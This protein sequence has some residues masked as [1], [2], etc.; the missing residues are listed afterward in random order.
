[1]KHP[2]QPTLALYAG[3]DLGWFAAKRAERHVARCR[4]CRQAVE[5]F[6]ALHD[7]LVGFVEVPALSW[8]R[9]AGEMKANIRLGLAAGECV[10]GELSAAPLT[11]ISG[12][13]AAMAC[14]G[15]VVLVAA[16][17]LLDRSTPPTPPLAPI[18]IDESMVLRATASGIELNQGGQSMSLQHVRA[19]QG[20]GGQ[21][22]VTYSAGAQGSMRARYVDLDTGYVTINNVYAQ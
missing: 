21:L 20:P 8:S 2:S 11:W 14:A 5:A 17:L 10:R 22:E 15:M 16:G 19:S 9:L 7:D 4:E 13:R 3:K 1:M 18:G 6:T 12:L